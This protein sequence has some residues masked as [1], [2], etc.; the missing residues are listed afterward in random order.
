MQVQREVG[1]THKRWFI[2]GNDN[3]VWVGGIS[4]VAANEITTY[5]N[6]M[7]LRTPTLDV[8]LV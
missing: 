1:N 6:T 7:L 8:R 3:L 5:A 4:W 2:Q